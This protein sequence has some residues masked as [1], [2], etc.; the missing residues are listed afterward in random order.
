MS[1]A[2]EPTIANT[3]TDLNGT[4]L[5][6]NAIYDVFAEYSSATSF[7]LVLSRWS[8]GGDGANNSSTS[9]A[10]PI[11]TSNT[12]PGPVVVSADSEV[13]SARAA[14]YAFDQTLT[15]QADSWGSRDSA[16]PH[17][18]MCNFNQ[19]VVINK[20]AIQ[21]DAGTGRCVPKT[22]TFEGTN[23]AGVAGDVTGTNGWV[24]LDT[25]T[26]RPDPGASG[27]VVASDSTT[28]FK[29]IN[30][31]PYQKYRVVITAVNDAFHSYCVIANLKLV[32]SSTSLPG[33]SSRVAAYESTVTY[34]IGDR[35]TYG[36]HD[37]VCIQSG[38]GQTPAAGSYWVDNG[39]SVSGDFAGL[40]R[41]DGVLVSSSS[42]TGKSRRWLGIIYTY[43]N[44]GTVNFKDDVNYRY[45]SNYY[46]TRPKEITWS[47]SNGEWS[48]NNVTPR[49]SNA[50]VG[51]I[52]GLL[53]SCL[54]NNLS[55]AS[56]HNAGGNSSDWSQVGTSL[57]S[58]SSLSI[59]I[60]IQPTSDI[61]SRSSGGNVLLPCGLSF[62]THT[63]S[64]N[65]G[66]VSYIR[67][68]TSCGTLIA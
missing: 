68:T 3:A 55:L 42:T 50:G 12:A 56:N 52:R 66:T 32:A 9:Y 45:V 44:S 46:N 1:A 37:W 41:H 61:G 63:E 5:M 10:T 65:S 16:F 35:V 58:T 33:S 47:N 4:A 24:V 7:N 40:Y 67:Q 6:P 48:C 28:Y 59:R 2:T 54:T 31:T 30:K 34:A 19:G 23:G 13:T 8:Q 27:W 51:A 53:I 20:Y 17:S 38:T 36:G 43:N 62:L 39:T 29:V 57:N 26:N 25:Q 60:N 64:V 14:W 11:M 15:A 21:S 49:E 22:W 18:L